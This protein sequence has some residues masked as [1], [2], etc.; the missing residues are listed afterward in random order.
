MSHDVIFYRLHDI[1]VKYVAK[2]FTRTPYK[3]RNQELLE[4]FHR[5]N[6]RDAQVLVEEFEKGKSL[7]VVCEGGLCRE[8]YTHHILM[9]KKIL[10]LELRYTI[11]Y[12]TQARATVEQKHLKKEKF[13]F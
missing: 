5:I 2:I 1:N 8:C 12:D 3:T 13:V 4:T 7:L 6:K 11:K 10:C 9:I